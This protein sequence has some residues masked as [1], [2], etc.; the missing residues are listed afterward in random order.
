MLIKNN[1]ELIRLQQLFLYL[2]VIS[3]FAGTLC[4][5]G[6]IGSFH[7]F[8]YRFLLIFIWLF[9]LCK[10]LTN[11]GR[12]NLLCTKVKWY[13]LFLTIWIGYATLSILWAPVKS[14]SIKN[15]LF[16]FMAISIILFLIHCLKELGSLKRLYSL[17]LLIFVALLIVGAWEVETGTHLYISGKFGEV[18]PR[19]RFAPTAVFYNQNDFAMYIAL[20]IPML[21]AWI[22][23]C[24]SLLKRAVGVVICTVGLWLLILTESRSCYIAVLM[25]VVFWFTFLL[26]LTAK[27][28]ALALTVFALT[29]CVSVFFSQVQHIL[30]IAENQV[31]SFASVLIKNGGIGDF[32]TRLNLVKN[33]FCFAIKSAGFGVGAGNVEYYMQNYSIYP[34]KEVTNLHNWLI[35]ILVNYGIFILTGYL[36]LYISL[37]YNLFKI[38]KEAIDPDDK[39]LSEGLLGGLVSF[40]MASMSSSSIIAF[41]P[42]WIFIGFTLAFLNYYRINKLHYS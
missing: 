16:L 7:L 28:K 11:N 1:M 21:I 40:L 10:V 14:Y 22:H 30:E 17:W 8:P 29:C 38:H 20:T 9:L 15:V 25:G 2:T 6:S 42:H 36:I 41:N 24:A 39:M 18:R 31:S 13:L 35:E 26:R 4:L 5:S 37:I 19:F 33:A 27:I 12:L 32:E 23:Y 3:A 34:V